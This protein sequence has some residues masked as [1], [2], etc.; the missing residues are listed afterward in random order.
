MIEFQLVNEN[1]KKTLLVDVDCTEDQFYDTIEEE[2]FRNTKELIN[3]SLGFLDFSGFKDKKKKLHLGFSSQEIEE[4]NFKSIF[5]NFSDMISK[6]YK[7]S[8]FRSGSV[9]Q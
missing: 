5:D 7:L 3:A 1:T 9:K 2:K 8:N 6:K 4:K